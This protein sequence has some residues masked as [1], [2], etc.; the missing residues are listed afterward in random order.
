MRNS[1]RSRPSKKRERQDSAAPQYRKRHPASRGVVR[2][3]SD[4]DSAVASEVVMTHASADAT[5]ANSVGA[6]EEVDMSTNPQTAPPPSEEAVK[7]LVLQ[8][9][10]GIC[11]VPVAQQHDEARAGAPPHQPWSQKW[12]WREGQARG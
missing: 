7:R 1:I 6:V 9:T 2:S 5:D 4:G 3:D 11:G 8:R 10:G 12:K